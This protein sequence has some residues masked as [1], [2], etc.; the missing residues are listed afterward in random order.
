M[1][2]QVPA[3]WNVLASDAVAHLCKLKAVRWPSKP[4]TDTQSSGRS[5]ERERSHA[6]D[7][8]LGIHAQHPPCLRHAACLP[9]RHDRRRN[10]HHRGLPLRVDP[11]ELAE[12]GRRSSHHRHHVHPGVHDRYQLLRLH[13]AT[14][15]RFRQG[16]RH[17]RVYLDEEGQ[18]AP[19][20]RR[21]RL[22]RH[23]G[24]YCGYVPHLHWEPDSVQRDHQLGYRCADGYIRDQHRLRAMAP[25]HPSGDSAPG[26]LEPAQMGCRGQRN[27]PHVRNLRVLLGVLAHLLETRCG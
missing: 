7:D 5:S 9:L 21:P 26:F 16:R 27:R 17:A 24:I 20:C 19:K 25:Y 13:F 11:A 18:P 2:G 15:V 10:R 3:M 6:Q 23:L 8:V 1:V 12:H 4:A 14:A 22:L